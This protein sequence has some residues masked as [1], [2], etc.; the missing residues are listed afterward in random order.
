MQ[1]WSW[2]TEKKQPKIIGYFINLLVS[3]DGCDMQLQMGRSIFNYEIIKT[4][5]QHAE[6]S[7]IIP[8]VNEWNDLKTKEWC[9]GQRRHFLINLLDMISML[10]ECDRAVLTV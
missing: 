1:S 6:K 4:V 9:R 3:L 8:R 2:N 10:K 7:K 5:L